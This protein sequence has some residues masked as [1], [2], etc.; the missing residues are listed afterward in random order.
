MVLV[1]PNENGS[2]NFAYGADRIFGLQINEKHVIVFLP[3]TVQP[4]SIL[5]QKQ[6]LKPFMRRLL[7][8]IVYGER[9]GGGATSPL[10]SQDWMVA[11]TFLLDQK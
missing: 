3:K 10:G 4:I 1:L 2:L 5:Y 11:E 7:C 8:H 9:G 6:Y